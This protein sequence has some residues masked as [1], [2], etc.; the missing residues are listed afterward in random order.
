MGSS[1]RGDVFNFGPAADTVHQGINS[2]TTST[3]VAG[4]STGSSS[5]TSPSRGMGRG[6]HLAKPSWMN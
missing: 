6:S 2:T 5:G 4:S 3:T 1:P